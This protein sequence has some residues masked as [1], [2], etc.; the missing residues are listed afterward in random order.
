MQA[1]IV[2]PFQ[3]VGGA[4][5]TSGLTSYKYSSAS[6]PHSANGTIYSVNLD[7]SRFADGDFVDVGVRLYIAG[8]TPFTGTLYVTLGTLV[9]WNLIMGGTTGYLGNDTR[10]S[11]SSA[12]TSNRQFDIS[13][14]GIFTGMGPGPLNEAGVLWSG[15]FNTLSVSITGY[16]AGTID[17][18]TVT[19]DA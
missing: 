6:G 7:L 15:L 19:V 2:A 3:G 1:G 17:I 11:R 4:G 16:V 13:A 8:G 10:I 5:G 12:T 18:V 14:P 9:I